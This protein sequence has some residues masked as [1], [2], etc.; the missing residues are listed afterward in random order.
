MPSM[1]FDRFQASRGAFVRWFAEYV[2]AA[3]CSL[4]VLLAAVLL[5]RPPRLRLSM[6]DLHGAFAQTFESHSD[7]LGPEDSEW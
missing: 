5:V 6:R 3:A 7:V 1:H 2:H 4:Q